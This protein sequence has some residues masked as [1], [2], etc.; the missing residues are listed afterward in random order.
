MDAEEIIE[1]IEKGE[2]AKEL[3][4]ETTT[5]SE[6]TLRERYRRT[7]FFQ[8]VDTIP[9]FEFGYWHETLGEWH[10]QGL[11]PEIDNERKAYEYFGIE[12]WRGAPVNVMGLKPSYEYKVID[13]SDTH[14]ESERPRVVEVHR[15][16]VVRE[17]R[18]FW[19]DE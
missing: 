5:S 3:K 14:D 19:N 11:P 1:S 12:N 10:K 6:M 7:M 13:Y 15:A 16:A 2:D 17:V 8:N 4:S 9:N 18:A